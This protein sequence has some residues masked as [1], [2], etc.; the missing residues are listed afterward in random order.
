MTVT[1][2]AL[3]MLCAL[4]GLVFAAAASSV[5]ARALFAAGFTGAALTTSAFALPDAVWLGGLGALAAAG[6]LWFESSTRSLRTIGFAVGGWLAGVWPALLETQGV[7]AVPAIALAG[8]LVVLTM[9]LAR[10]RAAFASRE[11]TEEGL[12]AILVLGLGVA[13]IPGVLDGWQAAV[14]LSGAT[15]RA[16][17]PVSLPVWTFAA[18]ATWS[19]LGALY[20]VWS[21]R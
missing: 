16:A 17:N 15:E 9:Y 14:N 21:R 18:L 19:S 6:L 7:P 11:L 8:G 4:G 10:T 20:S 12:L 1:F 13:A 2:H 5:P 3:W